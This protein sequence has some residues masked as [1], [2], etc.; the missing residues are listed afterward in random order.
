MA[1]VG[2]AM[3]EQSGIA[4]YAAYAAVAPDVDAFRG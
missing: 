4:V 1:Q 2:S 3:F